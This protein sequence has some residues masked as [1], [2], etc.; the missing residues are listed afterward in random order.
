VKDQP[1]TGGDELI[2]ILLWW[3]SAERVGFHYLARQLNTLV[4]PFLWFALIVL[5]K[6]TTD[7]YIG[8]TQPGTIHDI[9][10]L[11]RFRTSLLWA[12]MPARSVHRVASIFG[13]HYEITSM[14]AR[15]LGAKVGSRVYWP[16]TGPSIQNYDLL[17]IGTM[18]IFGSRSHIVTTDEIGNDTVR[19]G[20]GSTV[21]DRVVLLPGTTLG[22]GVVLGSGAIT[23][24][25][26]KCPPGSV[27]IGNHNGKAICL[28][29]CDKISSMDSSKAPENDTKVY[30]NI[31]RAIL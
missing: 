19:I 10:Q 28:S 11:A 1:S 23:E 2:S 18:F 4:R 14:I 6:R 8:K 26:E 3:A 13:T 16:G 21:A 30:L 31:E 25:N 5:A 20:T 22:E 12:S 9:S 15:A 24:R 7:K 27:W 17:E 29:G